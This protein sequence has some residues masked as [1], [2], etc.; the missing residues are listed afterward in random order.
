MLEKREFDRSNFMWRMSATITA[1]TGVFS[2]IVF[3]L[4]LANYLQIRNSD[5]MFDETITQMRI[6]YRDAPEKDEVLA[7]RIQQ[8]DLLNRKAFFTSQAFLR[9]GAFF[10]LISVSVFLIAFKNMIRWKRELPQLAEM[11]TAEVEFKALAESRNLITWAGVA[12]LAVG[13][14]S[15]FMTESILLSDSDALEAAMEAREAMENPVEEASGGE[16]DAAPAI[17]IEQPEWAEVE[18]EWATF[19]GP[20]SNGLALNTTAPLDWNLADGTN[21]KWKVENPKHG[22]NSPVIW[23]TKMFISGAD[24]EEFIV[25]CYDTE[26]GELLW[27]KP[28]GP[29]PKSPKELPEVSQE[30]GFAACTMALHGEQVFAIFANGDIASFDFEGNELWGKNLGLPDN[31]YGHSSSLVAYEDKLF[32]Q[33]DDMEVPHLVALNVATGEPEW[34]VERET[35][36]WASPILA[37]TNVGPQLIVNSTVNVDGYN[38]L[39]GKLLWTQECLDGEV[40]PSPA[41]SNGVVFVANEF[42]MATAIQLDGSADAVESSIKWE[43]DNYLPE[44]A[45]PVGDGERFYFG[46]S[47]GDIVCVDA[48]SGEELWAEEV[49]TGFYSSPILVGDN[50]YIADMDGNM[51]IFKAASEYELVKMVEMGE[52]T[53]ATPA[54]IHNRIYLRTSDNLYCIE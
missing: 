39:D 4:L 11:P 41:Y 46:T 38:P 6:E 12:I 19:R 51:Y 37:H 49:E 52:E 8:L 28:V 10:L 22:T 7:H 20:G 1:F 48:E 34:T 50:V 53:L 15:A 33:F 21:I 23:G 5:P 26:T 17:V 43:Y 42:A 14:M 32:V 24:E 36:S 16:S 40:A 2:L 3:I 54:F 31:H 44:V 25:Y 30:T 35:V 13:L 27:S 47:V 29:Y 9:F 45:S 18:K